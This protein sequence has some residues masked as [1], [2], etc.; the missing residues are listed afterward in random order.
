M[1]F[2]E[3]TKINIS[4]IFLLSFKI[5]GI[6]FTALTIFLS[7]WSWDDLSIKDW[8]IKMLI[9]LSIYVVSF[10]IA[11]I[12][13][14][15]I[16]KSKKIWSNGKN[17]AVAMYSDLFLLGF[18][19]KNKKNKIIV[20]PVNDTF[21]TIVERATE[22]ITK[23]L[24]SPNSNHGRWIM[25]YCKEYGI[26]PE[27]LN[28]RIQNNLKKQGHRPIKTYSIEEKDRGN[29][30]SYTLGTVAIIDGMNNNV[31]FYLLAISEFDENN[32]AK[33]NKKQIMYSVDELI[34]YYDKNGQA[35]PI[36]LP[37]MGTGRS[38]ANMS[39]EQSLKVIKSCILTSDKKIN[40]EMNIVVYTGDRNKVSIFK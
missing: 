8:W 20:I 25:N 33:S 27:D 23:P 15:F 5:S 1:N 32:N 16:L 18:N 21:E 30:D 37:L 35:D 24:V 29:R 9:L 3:K 34:D 28:T 31:K 14:I 12:L 39:H 7:F 22:E 26:T 38:R 40:G 2:Y 4:N 36:F 17:K 6:L 19:K 11:F 10:I 13:I